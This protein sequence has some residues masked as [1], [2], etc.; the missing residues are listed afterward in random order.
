[1]TS[2]FLMP[3]T[4]HFE[5]AVRDRYS[6]A[7]QK[8]VEALCCPIDYDRQF[9]KAIPQETIDRDYGCGD[10]SKN[11]RP[12]EPVLDLGRGGPHI[13]FLASREDGS[14]GRGIGVDMNAE[15]MALAR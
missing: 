15:M 5:S 14:G 4:I 13:C 3:A 7:A 11:L 12:G 8:K 2:K 9:L 10:P 6:A 1:M